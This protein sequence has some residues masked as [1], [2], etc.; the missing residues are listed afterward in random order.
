MS[1]CHHSAKRPENYQRCLLDEW[2]FTRG[3]VLQ[4]VTGSLHA[5]KTHRRIFVILTR[6]SS[7]QTSQT[8]FSQIASKQVIPM[9][10]FLVDQF[11]CAAD[12]ILLPIASPPEIRIGIGPWWV[13]LGKWKNLSTCK[14][15]INLWKCHSRWCVSTGASI[16]LLCWR[17]LGILPD[18]PTFDE[19]TSGTRTKRTELMMR[20]RNCCIECLVSCGAAYSLMSKSTGHKTEIVQIALIE[21]PPPP[22]F[23]IARVE[24]YYQSL[25]IGASGS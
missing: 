13:V 17:S 12:T 25:S 16:T 6:S 11:L 24:E 22:P 5:S 4:P 15:A 18:S 7:C 9:F 23:C 1:V 14:I 21:Y 3:A 2:R 8:L 10:I 20:R 19:I